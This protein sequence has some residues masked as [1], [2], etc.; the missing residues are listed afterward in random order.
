MK[1]MIQ[2]LAAIL[3]IVA[4]LV[5]GPAF[6]AMN[7]V[8]DE[9]TIYYTNVTGSAISAGDV[10]SL[11]ERYG[12]ALVNIANGAHGIVRTRGHFDLPVLKTLTSVPIG[13]NLYWDASNSNCVLTASGYPYIGTAAE[14]LYASNK[15]RRVSEVWIN[16]PRDAGQGS[17]L[18]GFGSDAYVWTGEKTLLAGGTT[19]VIAINPN[20]GRTNDAW[21]GITYMGTSMPT[22]FTNTSYTVTTS[23]LIVKGYGLQKVKWT[24]IGRKK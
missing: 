16:A 14:A 19:V 15:N 2:M 7:F 8:Q 3:V 13:T 4:V 10:V 20:L 9:G 5:A 21:V 24:I 18:S 12:V 22:G 11:G 17:V 23:G 1:N 6:G